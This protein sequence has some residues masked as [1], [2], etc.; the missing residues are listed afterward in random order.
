LLVPVAL[1][2]RRLAPTFAR[3]GSVG[4]PEAGQRQTGQAQ[5]EFFQRLPTGSGLGHSRGQF[6][7]FV[8][9]NFPFVFGLG[10]AGVS[11]NQAPSY[12]SNALGRFSESSAL[13][14]GSILCY[15]AHPRSL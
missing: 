15:S 13:S 10:L 1:H 14:A 3:L 8:I 7:E 5:A 11:S 6:I 12:S 2:T 4:Q 9:H